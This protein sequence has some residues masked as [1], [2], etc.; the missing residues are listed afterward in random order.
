LE[1]EPRHILD[2][3]S[4]AGRYFA[5]IGAILVGD[6]PFY[7]ERIE[8]LVTLAVRRAVPM[9]YFKREFVAAGGL[10]SYAASPTD[11]YR[12]AGV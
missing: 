12:Q 4:R 10:M 7:G 5:L 9:I 8:L 1:H 3:Q 6:D 2:D 11:G